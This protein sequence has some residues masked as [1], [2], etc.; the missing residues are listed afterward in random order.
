MLAIQKQNELQKPLILALIGIGLV[1]IV[2]TSFGKE[3]AK[4][5]TDIMYIAVAG[6]FVAL[7][8][9][10]ASRFRRTGSHG[11]AWL[12]FLGSATS[13]FIA[14]TTWMLYELVYNVNPFPSIADV[15]YIAGYPFLFG[16]LMYYLKP[17]KRAA[18]KKMIMTAMV[19]SIAVA[20]PSIYMAYSFDPSVSPL[21][22]ILATAYPISDA[23]VFVPALI[24]ISLFFRGEVNFTWSLICTGIF[25]LTIGDLGFQFT[26]FTNTYYTGHP[27]DIV[28]IW[29]YVLF[30]FG[31]YD[32]LKIFKKDKPIDFK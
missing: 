30:S 5:V 18:T 7:V 24:G 22:N 28:L 11:K 4:S 9:I 25:C 27:V 21:E 8:S 14:E 20:I 17:V 26:T 3:V 10:L 23:I 32:H 13:W 31:V 29:S 1:I 19:I 16:F 2:A 6:V 15:F 12:F